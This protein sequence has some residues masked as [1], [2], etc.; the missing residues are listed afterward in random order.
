MPVADSNVV[1]STHVR[2]VNG[3]RIGAVA[4]CDITKY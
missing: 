3:S 2:V 1:R 4:F